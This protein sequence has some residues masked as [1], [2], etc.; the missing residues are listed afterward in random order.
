VPEEASLSSD[1]RARLT[2]VLGM[3]TAE[4]KRKLAEPD[5]DFVT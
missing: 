2:R 1:Q 5:R 3:D 4:L